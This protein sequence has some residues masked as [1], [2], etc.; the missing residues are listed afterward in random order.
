[1][2]SSGYL[3]LFKRSLI[4]SSPLSSASPDL[5]RSFGPLA[6]SWRREARATIIGSAPSASAIATPVRQT[7][8]AWKRSWAGSFPS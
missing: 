3:Q 1:M 8:R 6:A 2:T 7:R 4:V 5:S